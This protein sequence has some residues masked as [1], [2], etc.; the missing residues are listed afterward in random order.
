MANP[1]NPRDLKIGPALTVGLDPEDQLLR[2]RNSVS[3]SWVPPS[4]SGRER[5][6]HVANTRS[7]PQVGRVS[8]F[9]GSCIFHQTAKQAHSAMAEN[10]P[11]FAPVEP[12]FA[13][14]AFAIASN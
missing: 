3:R 8:Y 4:L 14:F 10:S 2:E 5:Q 13:T 6:L 7:A 9:T 1:Q 12:L 11:S